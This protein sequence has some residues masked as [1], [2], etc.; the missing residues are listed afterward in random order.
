VFNAIFNI[1]SVMSWRPGFFLVEEGGVEYPEKT[2]E[3]SQVIDTLYRIM[4][5]RVHLAMSGIRTHYVR[6][7]ASVFLSDIL[8]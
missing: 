7:I 3:L 8:L 6:Y 4:L 5:Y 1:I 2:T